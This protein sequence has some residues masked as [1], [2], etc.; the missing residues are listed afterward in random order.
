MGLI[1]PSALIRGS[2]F[3]D[4]RPGGRFLA[5]RWQ[6]HLPLRLLAWSRARFIVVGMGR[7]A[8]FEFLFIPFSRVEVR[9]ISETSARLG[10]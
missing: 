3:P 9:I 1:G 7:Q 10:C 8:Q 6:V 5:N 4:M 2:L